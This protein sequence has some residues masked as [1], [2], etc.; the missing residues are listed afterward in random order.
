MCDCISRISPKTCPESIVLQF[1]QSLQTNLK[2]DFRKDNLRSLRINRH[3]KCKAFYLI[4]MCDCG[5]ILNRQFDLQT[6]LWVNEQWSFK[7]EDRYF[8]NSSDFRII[9]WVFKRLE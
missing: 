5:N 3:S 9:S 8:Q 2:E 4:T 1:K 6:C 7:S